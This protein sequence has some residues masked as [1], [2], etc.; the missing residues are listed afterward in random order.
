VH[1]FSRGLISIISAFLLTMAAGTL[2]FADATPVEAATFTVEDAATVGDDNP[3][4]GVCRSKLRPG[5][6]RRRCTLNAAVEEANALAG[7]HTINVPA[8][9]FRFDDNDCLLGCGFMNVTGKMT[10]VGAGS[11]ATTITSGLFRHGILVKPRAQLELKNLTYAENGRIENAGG[12]LKITNAVLKNNRSVFGGA[13]SLRPDSGANL[14]ETIV[15]NTRFTENRT[16]T[17]GPSAAIY[18]DGGSLRLESSTI[19]GNTATCDHCVGALL[20]N[21]QGPGVTTFVD[22]RNVTISGNTS[23]AATG[24]GGISLNTGR[25]ELRNTTIASNSRGG[26]VSV[27]GLTNPRIGVLHATILANNGDANCKG[28][29]GASDS[30]FDNLDSGSTCEFQPI[31]QNNLSN[32]DP[33]LGP[34]KNNGG[35]TLTHELLTGSPAI[36]AV[37]TC[38][39]QTDQRGVSRPQDGNGDRVTKCDIGAFERATSAAERPATPA[40]AASLTVASRT[41]DADPLVE[42]MRA[43]GRLA[44]HTVAALGS[45]ELW[46]GSEARF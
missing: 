30:T 31:G 35:V 39:V 17:V 29:L 41:A 1:R 3:G 4:D 40:D 21:Q 18:V 33:T 43:W 15:T 16:L 26:L 2:F 28:I 9:T 44:Q 34:L 12:N 38:E 10:I 14:G 23:T 36:D 20:I 46:Q 8:G 45:L 32:L 22:V 7:T 37:A 19:D 5:T 24:V 25:L 6:L 27:S 11:G 42:T 13:L